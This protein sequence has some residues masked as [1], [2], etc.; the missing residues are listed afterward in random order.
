MNHPFCEINTPNIKNWPFVALVVSTLTCLAVS[1]YFLQ[2]HTSIVFQNL[3][4][5]PILI[6]CVFYGRKGL[7]FSII[8]SFIY[9]FLIAIYYQD[10]EVLF[11]AFVRICIFILIAWVTS[12]LSQVI[13]E[14]GEKLKEKEVLFRGIFD[15]MPSGSVIYQITNR[16]ESDF[17]YIIEDMNRTALRYENKQ[18]SEVIGRTLAEVKTAIYDDTLIPRLGEVWKTEEAISYPTKII[19]GDNNLTYYENSHFKLPSGEIVSIYTDVTGKKL[20]EEELRKSEEKFR[21]AMEATSDGLWDWNMQTGEVYYSPGFAAIIGETHIDPRFESWE[22]RMHPDDR[23]KALAL[24]EDHKTGNIDRWRMEMRLLTSDESWKW[25]LNRGSVVAR[26]DLEKPARMIGIITD[27]SDQK[28]IEDII[29][30]E[31]D[32]AEQYLNIAE[33]IIVALSRN[34]TVVLINRKGAEMLGAPA[35]DIVGLN[36][37]DNF[38]PPKLKITMHDTF[39]TFIEGTIDVY[40]SHENEIIT[41]DG[42]RILVSWVNTLIKTPAGQIIGTLSSGEDLT[43]KRDL[44]QEKTRLLDQIQQNLAQ[45]AY[46]N[47]NIRNPLSIIMVLSDIHYEEATSQQIQEQVEIIDDCITKLDKRWSESEKVLNFIRKHYQITPK[48]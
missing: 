40:S 13:K 27:I 31:R 28:R 32:R 43:L 35:D 8:L 46:L 12:F 42:R 23:E 14:T 20:I 11:Q 47:D 22:S 25:V 2:I 10:N 9:F 39:N 37:F 18:R 26:D 1:I 44:E 21:L 48:Q 38:I 29:R 34:G 41:L 15:T 17:D 30:T 33:V 5:F 3:Y 45:M 7:I 4:Y 16:G 36:W 6:S 19:S 24:L